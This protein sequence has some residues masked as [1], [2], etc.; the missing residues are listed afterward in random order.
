[1]SRDKKYVTADELQLEETNDIV[2]YFSRP[3]LKYH[4]HISLNVKQSSFFPY[5][6]LIDSV[7]LM[8]VIDSS[9]PMPEKRVR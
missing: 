7:A 2:Y 1:M 4:L 5:C 6:G 3:K 9:S 8:S